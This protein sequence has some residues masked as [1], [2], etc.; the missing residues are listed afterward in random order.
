MQIAQE[1]RGFEENMNW[2]NKHYEKL[3]KQ[4]PDKYVAVFDKKVV[5]HDSDL[6]TLVRRLETNY[7]K[8]SNKIAVKYVTT[9]KI[10]LIL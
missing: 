5:D 6:S 7:A 10:E 2:L 1:L 4:Y 3:K 8:E 9:K